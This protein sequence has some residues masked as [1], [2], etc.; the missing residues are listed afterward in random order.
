MCGSVRGNSD[1]PDNKSVDL[2]DNS[3]VSAFKYVVSMMLNVSVY[4]LNVLLE[5]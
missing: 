5:R 1:N 4:C 3:F 2:S